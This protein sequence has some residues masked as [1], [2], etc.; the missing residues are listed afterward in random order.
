[1]KEN[2][3]EGRKPQKDQECQVKKTVPS[4]RKIQKIPELLKS[5]ERKIME[6]DML[7]LKKEEREKIKNLRELSQS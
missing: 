4:G 1:V 7:I 2:L 3:P 5:Q 6:T